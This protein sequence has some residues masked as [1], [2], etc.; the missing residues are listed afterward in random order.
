[1]NEILAIAQ[2]ESLYS[3]VDAAWAG[4]AM[5][6]PEFREIWAGIERADS[7]VFNPHKWLGANFDCSVQ[8]LKEPT[9]QIRTLAIRPQYLETLETDQMTNY[10]EWTIPLGRR[11]RALKLWFLL[12][13]YGLEGLR[14]RIRNHVAWANEAAMAIAKIPNMEIVTTP[15]LALF[16]FRFVPPGID[17][18]TATRTLLEAI[19]QDGRT[20]L[21][22][23][24]HE[25]KFVIRMSVGHF[26]TTQADVLD[27][28]SIVGEMARGL[29]W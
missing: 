13:A 16:T 15:R 17:P 20:Y 7:L 29:Q 21:T 3:H 14:G 6:C 19:N 28:V 9:D 23:T 2:Q 22:Q 26:E 25:G 12:R 1:L 5:I 11:F 24:T 4:S 18:D 10:S 27:A 8:F